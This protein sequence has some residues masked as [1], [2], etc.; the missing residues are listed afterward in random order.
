MWQARFLAPSCPCCSGI[1]V[2]EAA[3]VVATDLPAPPMSCVGSLLRFWSR[4]GEGTLAS[5]RGPQQEFSPS[6]SCPAETCHLEFCPGPPAFPAWLF[7]LL[8]ELFPASRSGSQMPTLKLG[9]SGYLPSHAL[10]AHFLF[11]KD[12]PPTTGIS[13]PA[14]PGCPP[15]L[16]EARNQS[17]GGWKSYPQA[18]RPHRMKAKGPLNVLYSTSGASAGLEGWAWV[19]VWGGE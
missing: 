12:G 7:R 2:V 19:C 13:I 9:R 16:P 3:Q 15:R 17:G 18:W 5:P 11:S 6:G 14:A 10:L 8:R 4:S 1:E